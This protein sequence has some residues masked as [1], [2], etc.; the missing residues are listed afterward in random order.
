MSSYLTRID[1]NPRRRASGRVLASPHRMHGAVNLC[2]P[3]SASPGRILWRVDRTPSAT[4][5]YIVSDI[6]PD[7]TGFVEEHGWP[8]AGGWMTRDYTPLL[9]R[10]RAGDSYV[11]RLTANPV[12]HLRPKDPDGAASDTAVEAVGAQ[13]GR[14]QR[15]A[16]TTA[17]HQLGWLVSRAPGWGFDVGVPDTP[18]ARIV[19]RRKFDFERKGN[20][21]TIGLASFEGTLTITD[22]AVFRE[23]LTAGIGPSKAY[24]CGMLTLA[25]VP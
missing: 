17:A 22:S 7:A 23:R 1:I 9:E 4:Y 14:G 18:T 21:V 8:A 11:F 13:R 24:G 20:R 3:P 6:A 15:W 19:E 16:H 2:F 10:L 12:R 5:L 25:P